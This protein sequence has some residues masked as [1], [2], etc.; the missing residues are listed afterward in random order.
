GIV[1]LGHRPAR[2]GGGRRTN[3]RHRVACG[4][5]AAARRLSVALRH[6]PQ[7][8]A[9]HLLHERRLAGRWTLAAS[10]RGRLASH[11]RRWSARGVILH[12]LLALPGHLPEDH[13]PYRPGEGC[14]HDQARRAAARQVAALAT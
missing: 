11:D 12:P 8:R 2:L 5:C 6:R 9:P 4:W 7:W 13:G 14:E 1:W 3:G 10:A